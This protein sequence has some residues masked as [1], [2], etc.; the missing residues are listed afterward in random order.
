VPATGDSFTRGLNRVTG[1]FGWQA[2]AA[3]LAVGVWTMGN[4]FPTG[5]LGR[6]ASRAPAAAAGL[7]AAGILGIVLY[8]SLVNPR[9]TPDQPVK[10]P[11]VPA[12]G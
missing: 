5:S 3:V 12:P 2:V 8:A 1:F 9:S 11:T 7:I 6:R 10:P 4:R